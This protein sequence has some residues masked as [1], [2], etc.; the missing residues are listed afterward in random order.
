LSELLQA[1]AR[2]IQENHRNGQ[3]ESDIVETCEPC[4]PPIEKTKIEKSY[5]Y[6][7]LG[8]DGYIQRMARSRLGS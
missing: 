1:I 2:R 8:R 7:L 4:T 6:R 3:D 5:F